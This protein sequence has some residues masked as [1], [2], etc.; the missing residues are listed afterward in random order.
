MNKDLFILKIKVT[1]IVLS[2]IHSTTHCIVLRRLK[3]FPKL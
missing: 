1:D 3:V 2:E